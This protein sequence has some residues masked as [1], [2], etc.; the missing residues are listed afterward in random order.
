MLLPMVCG[1]SEEG[2]DAGKK[3]QFTIVRPTHNVYGKPCHTMR[4]G[5]EKKKNDETMAMETVARQWN[6]N[7]HLRASYPSLEEYVEKYGRNP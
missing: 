2:K 4:F 5:C 1:C 3:P 7:L 6:R